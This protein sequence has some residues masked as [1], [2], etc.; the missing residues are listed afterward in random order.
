M[1]STRSPVL[2]ERH[3]HPAVRDRGPQRLAEGG[4]VGELDVDAGLSASRGRD[5]Q[6]VGQP[7]RVESISTP[8]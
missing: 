1:R 4:R 7:V 5:R 2:D 8:M 6:V 3:V